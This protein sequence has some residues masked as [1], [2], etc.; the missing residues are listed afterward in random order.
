MARGNGSSLLIGLHMSVLGDVPARFAHCHVAV[1]RKGPERS[2]NG[3]RRLRRSV[4][5]DG[6]S[7]GSKDARLVLLVP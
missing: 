4:G 6:D 3:A 2:M 5:D 7:Y 1:V